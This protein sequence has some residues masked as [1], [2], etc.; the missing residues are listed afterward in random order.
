[1]LIDA[2]DNDHGHGKYF[3]ANDSSALSSALNLA[4][5]DIYARMGS[6]AAGT[7]NSSTL[8]VGTQFYQALYDPT[9]WHGTIKAFNLNPSTGALGA[10]VW[11]TDTA[12]VS[13]S[14]APVFESWSTVATPVKITLDYANFSAAQQAALNATLPTNVSGTELISWAKGTANSKLRTRTRLLG[15]IVNSSLGMAIPAQKTAISLLGDTS[16]ITYLATKA[17]NMNS[18]ILEIGRAHV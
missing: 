2:A 1:M 12:I 8:Q 17:S 16:Y 7:G 6:A 13:G 14:T 10:P 18:S 4:L 11:T 9:D 15:D 3:Q 5:S